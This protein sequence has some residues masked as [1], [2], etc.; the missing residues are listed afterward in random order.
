ML[1]IQQTLD[2][3]L[4]YHQAG[5]LQQAEQLYRQV[6][7]A[8]PANVVALHLLG[9]I[10][11]QCGRSDLAVQWIGEAI[12]LHPDFAEARNNLGIILMEMGQLD[13]AMV[14]YREAL[15]LVPHFAQA[16]NNLGNC[17]K[18]QGKRAEAVASYRQALSFHPNYPEAFNNLGIM[19]EED[20]NLDDAVASARKALSL[21]P[22]YAE[23]CNNLGNALHKQGKVD[24]ALAAMREA[25]RL[26]P[27]F[28]PAHYNLGFM[29][30]E[31]GKQDEAV[32]SLLEALRLNPNHAEAHNN[33][34]IIREAQGRSAEAEVSLKQALVLKPDL[35]DAH[36]NL[37]Q[38]LLRQG[39]LQQGWAE[40]EWRCRRPEFPPPAFAQ[41]FWQG[42]Q[43]AGRTI[44]LQA[45]QGM[46]DTIQ[47]V[48]YA[49]MVKDR[50]AG[51][52][53][54]RCQPTLVRLL[55]HCP[56][57]DRALARGEPVPHF[58]VQVNLL[59][60]PH[61]LGTT[62]VER[63]PANVPYLEAEPELV[64]AWRSR[65]QSLDGLKVGIQW[66]G[67]PDHRGDR[68]RS[69]ALRHFAGLAR[70]AGQPF[71][72]DMH[73]RLESLTY[74]S[75][76]KG[77]GS[78]QLAQ[79]PGLARDVGP[80]LMDFADTAAVLMNLDLVITIDTAVAHLA[81]ALGRPVW[82]LLP[83][84]ADWRWL[85]ERDDSPWYPTMRLFRQRSPGAWDDVFGRIAEAMRGIHL[86]AG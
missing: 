14:H 60:L 63:I 19:Y 73:F 16:H 20:G 26:N 2:L 49:R 81:G 45:E 27:L 62:G 86:T 54:L 61:L 22:N 33:L 36:Y 72:A 21:M 52:V 74:V 51:A 29:L 44:L 9:L 35:V 65:L 84:A 68:W 30:G 46:G 10:A 39:K 79:M 70:S 48:R 82:V 75:L 38:V 64:N 80:D 69:V 17:L 31:Q 18:K 57:I 37:A 58:D 50:G 15:R 85:L 32:A 28:A 11:H 6:L 8:D 47:F 66:Q 4:Q 3:A 56:G 43:L 76:Q 59:S 78:E 41:P 7:Q 5:N 1:P 53:W 71:Q 67:N 13:E 34:G 83:F 42:E 25:L 24:E 55:R 12:R 40:Y 77:H 23:A